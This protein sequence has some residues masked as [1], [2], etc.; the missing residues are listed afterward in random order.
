MSPIDKN[1]NS[2]YNIPNKIKVRTPFLG[3]NE[4]VKPL[5]KG[6]SSEG[7]VVYLNL[8]LIDSL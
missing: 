1:L 7:F 3:R 2:W 5:G 8:Q 4:M 6:Q